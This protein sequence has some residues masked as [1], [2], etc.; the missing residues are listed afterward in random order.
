MAYERALRRDVLNPYMEAL[1]ARVRQAEA[2]YAAIREAI[3]RI[4][5]SPDLVRYAE[6]ARA[7]LQAVRAY[8][9]RTFARQMSRAFGVDV[10]PFIPGSA[11]EPYMAQAVIDNV[12][13]IR[14]IPIRA[15]EALSKRITALQLAAPFDQRALRTAFRETGQVSGYNLRRLTRDQ[16]S[17]AIG[18]F[19]ETR[20]KALGVTEYVWRTAQD[21]RVRPTHV[22]NEGQTFRWDSPP[23][24]TGHPGTDVQCRC[25]ANP[26]VPSRKRN[27]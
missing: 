15:H 17:K 14:T 25:V 24:A 10:N 2:D 18:A 13:L 21:E 23:A 27:A 26:V 6:D 20:Q 16:T 3:R 5:D 9:T 12:A 4:P 19:N 22:A 8:H 1:A 7:H 11:L